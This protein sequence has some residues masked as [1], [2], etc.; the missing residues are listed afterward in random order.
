MTRRGAINQTAVSN[1]NV[2]INEVGG[3][4]LYNDLMFGAKYG[5]PIVHQLFNLMKPDIAFNGNL[6]KEQSTHEMQNWW[7]ELT[8]DP[9]HGMNNLQFMYS[10]AKSAMQMQVF[11]QIVEHIRGVKDAEFSG[12]QRTNL[13]SSNVNRDPVQAAATQDVELDRWLNGPQEQI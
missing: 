3:K 11:P 7:N 8:G 9:T 6:T 4:E 10:M 5:G 1:E 12:Q 2:F 13:G